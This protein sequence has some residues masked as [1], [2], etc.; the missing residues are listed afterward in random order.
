MDHHCVWINV[1]VGHL[2]HTAFIAFLFFLTIGCIHAII[3][4]SYFLYKLFDRVSLRTG[5]G[6]GGGEWLR[7]FKQCWEREWQARAEAKQI[8]NT[9][10]NTC[11]LST[12]IVIFVPMHTGFSVSSQSSTHYVIHSVL[13]DIWNSFL[14]WCWF[15]SVALIYCSGG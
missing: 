1:C 13:C 2:N 3:L 6:S 15:G 8:I 7:R 4:N 5:R 10:T 11:F 14:H 12:F 9:E